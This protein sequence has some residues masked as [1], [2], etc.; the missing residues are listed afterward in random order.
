LIRLRQI[1][2]AGLGLPR[3]ST[4]GRTAIR[5]CISQLSSRAHS[6]DRSRSLSHARDPTSRK[7]IG[8]IVQHM[9]LL[10]E[11]LRLTG[12]LLE[13]SCRRIAL[14]L[15]FGHSGDR[16]TRQKGSRS[17]APANSALVTRSRIVHGRRF[18]VVR[19]TP[20]EFCQS[21]RVA[22]HH[23][24]GDPGCR[25]VQ[26]RCEVRVY[27]PRI[28]QVLKPLF[29]APSPGK[30]TPRSALI[31]LAGFISAARSR[32]LSAR[33]CALLHPHPLSLSPTVLENY[34]AGCGSLPPC[35]TRLETALGAFGD[36]QA[37]VVST[38]S[39]DRS[40]PTQFLPP[41]VDWVS[42]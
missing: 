9:T 16:G 18:V 21:S 32:W 40:L 42:N 14:V 10:A 17:L 34:S 6:P 7:M 23:Q 27:A 5:P 4:I 11:A 20:V 1:G 36:H 28:A 25:P 31:G 37:K 24:L 12:R 22:L 29:R 19:C 2:P 8:P 3:I 15:L 13:R 33:P 39:R 38:L 41:A 30:E 26:K 35:V